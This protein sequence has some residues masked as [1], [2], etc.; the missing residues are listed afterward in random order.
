MSCG[1]AGVS[2][3]DDQAAVDRVVA[4]CGGCRWPC[5]SPAALRVHD[6]PRPTS[7]L[8]DRLARQG[9][10]AFA[11]GKLSLAR[12]IGAGFDRL[13]PVAG[14]LFLELGLLPLPGFGLWTAAALLEGTDA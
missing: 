10:Q 9:R 8:A 4:L 1:D 11:Y 12:T 3:D 5:G 14:Q 2:I 7:E 13:D 6:H